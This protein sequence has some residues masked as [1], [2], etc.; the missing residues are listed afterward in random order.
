[1]RLCNLCAFAGNPTKNPI[2]K[3]GVNFLEISYYNQALRNETYTKMG[4]I[5]LKYNVI[6]PRLS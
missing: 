3:D 2:W 6:S 1:M 5:I 4:L